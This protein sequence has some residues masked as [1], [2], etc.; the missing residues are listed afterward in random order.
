M[1][2]R[3]GPKQLHQPSDVLR[4][5][6][7]RTR[8][9]FEW[10]RGF[11]AS[12]GFHFGL[13]LGDG[14]LSQQLA[15]ADQPQAV[16]AFGLIHD[17]ARDH[18]RGTAGRHLAKAI[19]ELH[20]QLRINTD[21][22]FVE[23]QQVRLVDQG[24]GERAARSHPAAQRAHHR[25]AA[26]PQVDQLERVAYP[27]DPPIDGAKEVHVLLRRQVGIEGSLR[28]GPGNRPRVSAR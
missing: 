19:P 18:D 23:Q 17:V 5:S 21:G 25:S 14:S 4:G 26:I 13:D 15:E 20:P 11:A 24:A 2:H 27:V 10:C 8:K 7:G 22:W 28:L 1:Q 3:D 6:L 16:A 9:G 12:L